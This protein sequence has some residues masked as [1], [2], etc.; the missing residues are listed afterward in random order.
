[1]AENKNM[2][3][4]ITEKPFETVPKDFSWSDHQNLS[5]TVVGDYDKMWGKNIHPG[6]SANSTG[7]V[8]LNG[9]WYV[10]TVSISREECNVGILKMDLVYCSRGLTQPYS[11][12]IEVDMVEVQKNLLTHPAIQSD[13]DALEQIRGWE[14]YRNISAKAT[15]GTGNSIQFFYTTDGSDETKV[16]NSA[17]I[18]YCKAV[19]AGIETYNLYLPVVSRTSLYLRL[20]GVIY[21]GNSNMVT[22]G[23]IDGNDG[24]GDFNNPPINVS[25]AKSGKWFKS[26]DT[27]SQSADG[28]WTRTEQW[29]FTND[30]THEWI[31]TGKL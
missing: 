21:D 31:Y 20:P 9:N 2:F 14:R 19:S 28:S 23:T 15:Q 13:D 12:T 18:A 29:T 22:G 3:G 17:A 11:S 6:M 5:V 27:Y 30:T 7:Y 10:R 8:N 26:R 24:I 25:G 4:K 1:M 16:D